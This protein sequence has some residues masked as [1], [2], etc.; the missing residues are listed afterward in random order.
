MRKFKYLFPAMFLIALAGSA[1][2]R[3][4]AH[5]SKAFDWPGYYQDPYGYCDDYYVTDPNCSP[6]LLGPVCEEYIITDGI[7]WTTIFEFG[8][9]TTC[10]QP[11][12]SLYPNEP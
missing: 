9:T 3:Q 5:K 8:T 4:S 2:T 6:D 12:Y 7:G 10:W 11:L 1:F